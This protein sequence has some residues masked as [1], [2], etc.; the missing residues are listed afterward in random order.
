MRQQQIQQCTQKQ[1]DADEVQR[2]TRK[3]KLCWVHKH[4]DKQKQK[5]NSI[6]KIKSCQFS[7]LLFY[8]RFVFSFFVPQ[9][10]CSVLA[11]P[12]A[13]PIQFELMTRT[14]RCVR[15]CV[16]RSESHRSWI[17]RTLIDR[18][19][20]LPVFICCQMIHT[21]C[22]QREKTKSP[23]LVCFVFSVRRN[24]YVRFGGIRCRRRN[25]RKISVRL[26]Q[27]DERVSK[28]R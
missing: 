17:P 23:R 5:K 28:R 19:N 4:F 27:K 18:P 26:K 24:A 14:R 16:C 21:K 13:Q 12:L 2:K 6:S 9:S 10:K 15:V 20:A 1:S 3:Q 8:F 11:A 22:R 7:W 25:H